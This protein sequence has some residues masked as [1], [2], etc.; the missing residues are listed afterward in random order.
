MK[1]FELL[2]HHNPELSW[3]QQSYTRQ[4]SVNFRYAMTR[5]LIITFQKNE[6]DA[7]AIEKCLAV[8]MIYIILFKNS[9]MSSLTFF[10][11][12]KDLMDKLRREMGLDLCVDAREFANSNDPW[13]YVEYDSRRSIYALK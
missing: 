1:T 11:S 6:I 5:Y 4:Y 12:M 9:S 2:A 8:E 3:L 7:T 13:S 10:Y